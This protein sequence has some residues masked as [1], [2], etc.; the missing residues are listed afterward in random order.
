MPLRVKLG[1]FILKDGVKQKR[2]YLHKE[3]PG[4]NH[5]PTQC[6]SSLQDSKALLVQSGQAEVLDFK[7]GIPSFRGLGA[8]PPPRSGPV[9][10]PLGQKRAPALQRFE[11][12]GSPFFTR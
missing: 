3:P 2:V 8:P 9:A 10:S 5:W 7:T 12:T 11:R 1:P 4:Q 6:I